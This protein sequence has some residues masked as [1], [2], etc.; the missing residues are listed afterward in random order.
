MLLHQLFQTLG[1]QGIEVCSGGAW[2]GRSS[3]TLCL[4]NMIFMESLLPTILPNSN[5]VHFTKG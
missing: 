5:N 4:Q 1:N 2:P 3:N